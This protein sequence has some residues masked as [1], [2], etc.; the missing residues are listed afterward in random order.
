MNKKGNEK[1]Y[2]WKEAVIYEV[3]VDKFANNFRGMIEKIPYLKHLGVNCVWILPYY[4]SPM[5][6]DGYDVSDYMNIREDLGTLDDFALFVNEAHREG[7]K[8]VVELILNHISTNH[9]WFLDASQS[10]TSSRRDFFLWS[11]DGIGF[12]DAPNPFQHLKPANWIKNKATDDYYFAT[13]YPE[14]ADLNWRNPRVFEE[15]MKVVDFW[16]EKG[17]DG[18]RLDAIPF[19]IKKEETACVN[20]PEVHDIIRRLRRHIDSKNDQVI[21]LAE[22]SGD[23]DTVKKYFGSGDECHMAFNFNMMAATLLALKRGDKKAIGDSLDNSSRIPDNCQWANFLRSHDDILFFYLPEREREELAIWLGA[24]DISGKRGVSKRL[25]EILNGNAKHII[26][27]FEILA[28]IP[29]SPVIYYG[30]EIG[31]RNAKLTEK[32][33][34]GRRYLRG[35]FNWEE[36]EI[37]LKDKNSILNQ[38]ALIFHNKKIIQ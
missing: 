4:P 31:I 3:Y 34:D 25:A 14:Q 18:F 1:K 32:P 20:L 27:A 12:K 30:D 26:N 2:W 28:E 15:M 22:V 6:D 38:V 35:D 29:G 19:L 16:I 17:V 24:E 23:I 36:A 7:I 33:Q 5:I 11:E 37:Q 8:V 21:L 9:P 13:F 10:K